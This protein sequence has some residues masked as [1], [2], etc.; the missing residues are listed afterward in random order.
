ML[1][2]LLRDRRGATAVEYSLIAA[3]VGVGLVAVLH[4]MGLSLS[5]LFGF[6]SAQ[7]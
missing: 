7:L 2:N 6:V 5:N 1:R 3:L 4:F